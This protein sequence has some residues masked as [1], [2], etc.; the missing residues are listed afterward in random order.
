M[1]NAFWSL[2]P[3]LASPA[4]SREGTPS[5]SRASSPSRHPGQ[6]R[7]ASPRRAPRDVS[8]SFSNPFEEAI[9]AAAA[10]KV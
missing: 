9:K 10:D 6:S 5:P 4:G 8:V 2:N 7:S 1:A 3:E